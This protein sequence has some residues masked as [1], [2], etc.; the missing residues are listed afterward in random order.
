MNT[1]G[2]IHAYS[3][4]DINWTVA[5]QVLLKHGWINGE[6]KS[7][8]QKSASSLTQFDL[9]WGPISKQNLEHFY[10]SQRDKTSTVLQNISSSFRSA[11]KENKFLT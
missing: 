7:Y 4:S 2:K 9:K 5:F 11:W 8:L 10:V 3:S 1:V 6:W